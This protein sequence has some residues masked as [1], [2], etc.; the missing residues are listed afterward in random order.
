MG[1]TQYYTAT[2]IDGF[3]ADSDNSLAWLFESDRGGEGEARFPAFFAGVGAMC[4]GATTY[5]WVLDHERLLE[6]PEKWRDYYGD[7][8]CWVFTHRD[9]PSIPGADLRFVSGD[10]A[11]AHGEMAA[12]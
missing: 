2:S 9:L 4:M 12:S 3:I 7:T 6:Q 11:P 5:Q 10:V 1:M 8:P